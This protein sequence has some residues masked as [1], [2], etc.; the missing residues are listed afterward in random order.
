MLHFLLDTNIAIHV[1]KRRPPLALERFNLHACPMALWAIT[2]SEL[3][4]GTERSSAPESF[5]EVV[6]DFCSSLIS[7]AILEVLRYGPK[8]AQP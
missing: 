1:I 3:P 4:H 8:A 6:E 7:A 5:L 2:L